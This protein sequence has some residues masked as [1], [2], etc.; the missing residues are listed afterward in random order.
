MIYEAH[1]KK[2]WYIL[3]VHFVNSEVLSFLDLRY[4]NHNRDICHRD[5]FLDFFKGRFDL[6]HFSPTMIIAPEG[7]YLGECHRIKQT[8]V[9]PFVRLS[10]FLAK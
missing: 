4:L 8:S 2:P 1:H 3:K 10:G 9:C 7:G 5:Y 6:R